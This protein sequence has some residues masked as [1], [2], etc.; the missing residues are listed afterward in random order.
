MSF[1]DNEF[2]QKK[3]F[4]IFGMDEFY[5]TDDFDLTLKSSDSEDE[6]N[7]KLFLQKK[8]ALSI[9]E[10]QTS[11]ELTN[12]AHNFL[13]AFTKGKESLIAEAITEEIEYN[14]HEADHAY[15]CN[16]QEKQ[17]IKNL[18]EL[19]LK[20]KNIVLNEQDKKTYFKE[21]IKFIEYHE[22][23]INTPRKI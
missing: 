2:D 22:A 21:L 4:S 7:A 17:Q 23:K 1:N 6:R 19:S 13:N 15:F 20:N 8:K 3:Y 11:T 12:L 9:N 10:Q 16:E 14:Y 5:F 18:M